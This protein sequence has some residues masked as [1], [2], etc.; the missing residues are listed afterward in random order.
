VRLAILIV[1]TRPELPV[2]IVDAFTRE[3]GA[4]NRAGIVLD[5]PE[6]AAEE[7]LAIARA[8]AASET[9]FVRPG[10]D[11]VDYA[12]RYFAP[13]S[14]IDFCGHNTVA[15]FH[16]LAELGRARAPGRYTLACPAGRVEV[17]LES[18]HDHTRVWMATP[19][20]PWEPCAIPLERLA[21]L[22]GGSRSMLAS[23]LPVMR[24]G[25][26]LYV[27]LE[28]RSD[29]T[30]L[31]PRWNELAAEGLQHGVKGFYAFTLETQEPGHISQARF[32][33][34]ALGV[35]EDPVTG[36]AS[37]PF[38]EYLALQGVLSLPA[39][40]GTVRATAEQG[41]AMDKPGQAELEVSGRPG[42]IERVRVGGVAVTVL[43]G[44][45]RVPHAAAT[46]A[47]GQG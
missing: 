5:A 12:F 1:M 20:A 29:L 38:A 11:G 45:L 7:M 3:P 22:L 26:K 34:P 43:Q 6:L 40:G 4:G 14:E 21:L 37:G 33:A 46:A 44:T 28:R 42:T 23:H 13:G 18:V 35:R 39:A 31:T 41:Y 16:L 9:A 32:F 24:S 17:E 2:T 15:T 10:S 19:R 30:T 36:S 27:P 47:T 8:V 25:F